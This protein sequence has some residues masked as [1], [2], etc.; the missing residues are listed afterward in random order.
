M[1]ARWS[2]RISPVGWLVGWLV[3]DL[4]T[5]KTAL[6]I[7]F[8]LC[9]YLGIDILR[10]LTEPFFLKK[11]LVSYKKIVMC[12]FGYLKFCQK[13]TTLTILLKLSKMVDNNERNHL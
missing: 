9:N 6:T 12:F 4:H 1:G 13:E 10:R 5:W 8:K 11:N 7:F 2:Y 3:G